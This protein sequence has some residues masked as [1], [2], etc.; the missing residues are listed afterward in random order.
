MGAPSKQPLLRAPSPPLQLLKGKTA[1]KPAAKP[2]APKKAAPAPKKAAPAP[3]KA[4]GTQRAGGAGYK[5][6]DG[7]CAH[8]SAQGGAR[9]L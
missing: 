6:Y 7:E 2:A 4:A 3:K 5:K 8:R 9:G 1:A